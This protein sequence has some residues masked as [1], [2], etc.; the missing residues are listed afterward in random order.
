MPK[1]TQAR[2]KMFEFKENEQW[3]KKTNWDKN[4]MTRTLASVL[5]N[6]KKSWNQCIL[7]IVYAVMNIYNVIIFLV[8]DL[9]QQMMSN[10]EMLQQALD[11]PLVQSITSNPDLMRSVMMSNPEMQNLVEVGSPFKLF[12]NIIK[13]EF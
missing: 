4:V 5:T 8:T 10:P 13:V 3:K 1:S 2:F 9:R 12:H 11:N 7:L 6:Y